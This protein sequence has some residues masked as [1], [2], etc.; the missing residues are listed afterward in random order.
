MKFNRMRSNYSM[1]GNFVP[2]LMQNEQRIKNMMLEYEIQ[3]KVDKTPEGKDVKSFIFT[4]ESI[5]VRFLPMRIDYDFAYAAPTI[6]QQQV[7]DSACQ[8]YKLFGEIFPEVTAFRL[9]LVSTGFVDNSNIAAIQSFSNKFGF[10][11]V[12]GETTELN[13]RIN[14]PKN[15]FEM[16]NSVLDVRPGEAKN[17]KTGDVLPVMIFSIDINTLASNQKNRFYPQDVQN[18]F[19]EFLM[20]EQDK[21]TQI[22]SI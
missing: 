16:I 9:A 3:T 4:K 11:G 18:F 21:I 13:F 19:S 6:T 22:E 20:E 8:F 5:I 7:Y 14:N 17:H 12:F 15:S 10:S 1:I 2:F